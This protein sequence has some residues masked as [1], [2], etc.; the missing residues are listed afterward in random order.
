MGGQTT[1]GLIHIFFELHFRLLRVE[2]QED[3]DDR[4]TASI[5]WLL[6]LGDTNKARA[7]HFWLTKGSASGC[8]MWE[9]D[10]GL[11]FGGWN[12]AYFTHSP[13]GSGD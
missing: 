2:H 13:K 4:V 12:D 10:T 9:S 5:E 1:L 3:W 6:G 11:H 7:W 8:D